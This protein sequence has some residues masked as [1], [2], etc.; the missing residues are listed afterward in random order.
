MI[1]LALFLTVLVVAG[2]YTYYAMK[3]TPDSP[4]TEE[5]T[6]DTPTQQREDKLVALQLKASLLGLSKTTGINALIDKCIEVHESL[7]SVDPEASNQLHSVPADF[8]RLI[9]KHLPDLM[10]KFGQI[11]SSAPEE[12][13]AEFEET[14]IQLNLELEEILSNVRERNYT[15][16]ANKHGFMKIRYSDKF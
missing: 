7:A 10:N 2:A 14:L 16:F 3:R 12:T 11:S 6:P 1:F 9:G 15:A 8:E 13:F 4:A 5:A